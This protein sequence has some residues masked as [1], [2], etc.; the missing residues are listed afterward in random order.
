MSARQTASQFQPI[1]SLLEA[2]SLPEVADSLL[3]FPRAP[4]LIVGLNNNSSAPDTVLDSG[5]PYW[6]KDCVYIILTK[7]GTSYFHHIF[8][9]IENP[10]LH[11]F[12]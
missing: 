7:F 5:R 10:L 9:N 11:Y 6:G 8:Y 12:V 3:S 4:F 1:F 2:T